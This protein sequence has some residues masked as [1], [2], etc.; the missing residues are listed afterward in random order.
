V[1]AAIGGIS[2]ALVA[3]ACCIGPVAFSMVG[4]GAVGAS[5]V[6]LERYRPW[7]LDCPRQPHT[8]TTTS[9]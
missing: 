9:S 2:T 1:K 4:V 7:F 5:A 3:S 8:R 6:K